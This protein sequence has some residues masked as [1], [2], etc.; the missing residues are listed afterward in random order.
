[1][2]KTHNDSLAPKNKNKW[3][4]PIFSAFMEMI[5]GDHTLCPMNS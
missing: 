5:T 2:K 4:L 1:M 3:N